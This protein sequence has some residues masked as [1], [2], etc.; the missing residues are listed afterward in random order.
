MEKNEIIKM[1]HDPSCNRSI[2]FFFIFSRFFFSSSKKNNKISYLTALILFDHFNFD[3]QILVVVTS[4]NL[5]KKERKVRI[6]FCSEFLKSPF[7]LNFFQ[8]NFLFIINTLNIFSNNYASCSHTHT[9]YTQ[10]INLINLLNE[11]NILQEAN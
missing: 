10:L 6:L 1:I 11:I 8:Q 3:I 5:R 4:L 9:H 2:L 7:F